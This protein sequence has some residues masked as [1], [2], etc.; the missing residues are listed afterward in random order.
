MCAV[1]VISVVAV[2][3]VLAN[4]VTDHM[5]LIKE[6]MEMLFIWSLLLVRE[7]LPNISIVLPVYM[8]IRACI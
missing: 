2:L 5:Q 1:C 8:Y 6:E 3:I 4:I 7:L